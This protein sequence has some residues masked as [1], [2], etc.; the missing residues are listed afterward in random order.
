MDGCVNRWTDGVPQ[1]LA[2]Y[3]PDARFKTVV[4]C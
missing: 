3:D 2:E 1:V 4:V